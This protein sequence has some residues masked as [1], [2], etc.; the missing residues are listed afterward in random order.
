M[1]LKSV[2]KFSKE[3]AGYEEMGASPGQQVQGR[4]EDAYEY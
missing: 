4:K 1:T 3:G 2:V